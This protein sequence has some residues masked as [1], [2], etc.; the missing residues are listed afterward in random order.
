MPQYLNI[1]D[2]LDARRQA[3]LKAKGQ[4]PRTFVVG[5]TGEA[6]GC[7]EGSS[8]CRR[9]WGNERCCRCC[10][11]DPST[12]RPPVSQ[13]VCLLSH[14]CLPADVGK[15]TLCK[16]LLNYG[17]R[18]GWAPTFVDMD[19]GQG[20][21][22]VPGCI[23]ATPGAPPLLP[24]RSHGAAPWPAWWRSSCCQCSAPHAMCSMPAA[25]PTP[26]AP[27]ACPGT[28]T[29]VEAPIDVEDGLPTD[30]PLVYYTGTPTPSGAPPGWLGAS[31]R[32]G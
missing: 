7:G 17:V 19:I 13:L 8:G 25:S 16:I 12:G 6:G 14:P 11:V 18:A 30:A 22:T 3:A 2:V 4:G 29:A 31:H 20:S 10:Q 1:H 9:R 5:P 23:A 24:L 28:Q 15:S 26:P 21:I 27:P 32:P